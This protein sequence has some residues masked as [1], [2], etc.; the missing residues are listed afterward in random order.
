MT[1]ILAIAAVSLLASFICSLFE[2]ALYA[3]TPSEIE[4][5]RAKKVFGAERMARMRANIEEPIAAILTF[6]T[7]ANTLGATLGGFLVGQYYSDYYAQLHGP[8]A[9]NDYGETAAAIFGVVFTIAVLVFSEIIPKS[10][11]VRYARQ[12]T[13]LIAWPLQCMTWVS[14]PVARAARALMHLLMR[15]SGE[16]GPTSEEVLTLSRMARKGGSIR[17]EELAWVENVLQL[18]SVTAH[19]LMTPRTVVDSLAAEMPLA[20]IKSEKR[21]WVHT[22]LPLFENGNPDAVIGIVHGKDLFLALL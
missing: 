4:V 16:E 18:D 11:G 3:I 7:V 9:R 6:N 5:Q 14:W 2:A 8:G 21:Q 10:L 1:A 13:S 12:L 22:R 19:E 20:D 15:S 17:A